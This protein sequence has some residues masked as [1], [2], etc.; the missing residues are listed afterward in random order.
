MESEKDC[1]STLTVSW[2]NL[3]ALERRLT[4]FPSNLATASS[5][6]C[7]LRISSSLLWSC[8]TLSGGLVNLARSRGTVVVGWLITGAGGA[9]V[10]AAGDEVFKRKIFRNLDWCR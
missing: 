4:L 2:A 7:C 8:G 1:S 6:A 9:G 5:L 10:G 3:S